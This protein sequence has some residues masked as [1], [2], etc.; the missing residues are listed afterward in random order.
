MTSRFQSPVHILLV[1]ITLLLIIGSQ[2]TQHAVQASPSESSSSHSG[3]KPPTS[4]IENASPKAETPQAVT[5][6][7]TA[8]GVNNPNRDGFWFLVPWRA[9]FN[10]QPQAQQY[11]ILGDS[12]QLNVQ[13]T[14]GPIIWPSSARIT[15]NHWS[16][17]S[18]N[19]WLKEPNTTIKSNTTINGLHDT[20]YTASGLPVGVHYFQM[21]VTYFGSTYYSQLAMITVVEKETPATAIDIQP[22]TSVVFANADYRV[23]ANLTPVNSTSPVSWASPNVTYLPTTG[24]VV[25]FKTNE[26]AGINESTEQAGLPLTLTGQI[27]GLQDNATVYVGGLKALTISEE[28]ARQSGLTWSVEGLTPLV[29]QYQ[30]DYEWRYKWVYYDAQNI[31]HDFTADQALNASGQIT[32]LAE[33]NTTK[34]LMI[35]KNSS[36][37]ELAKKATENKQPFSVKLTLTANKDGNELTIP[38]NQARLQVTAPI[39]KLALKQVPTFAFT[40]VP[41]EQIYTGNAATPLKPTATGNLEISD[42]RLNQ[43]WHLQAQMTPLTSGKDLLTGTSLRLT[44]LPVNLNTATLTDQNQL[45]D[46]GRTVQMTSGIWP[47]TGELHL[48][49]N[50]SI[51]LAETDYFSGIITWQLTTAT[52]AVTSLK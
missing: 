24:R 1:L 26:I 52:P 35:P 49:A 21:A 15:V 41:I 46:L 23:Q 5:P 18:D 40:D 36:F 28:A 27:N 47:I 30:T 25:R 31:A 39:G 20:T 33:L 48:N 8:D 45:T 3:I 19:T 37:I 10:G 11:I 42:T 14:G 16:L 32:N 51:E 43:N 17:K 44:G 4:S 2:T 6:P 12:A 9:G 7:S 34:Q 29:E 38:T 50:S 13:T 22:N